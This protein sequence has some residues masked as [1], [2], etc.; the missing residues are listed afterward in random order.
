MPDLAVDSPWLVGGGIAMAV[1]LLIALTRRLAKTAITVIVV[2]LIVAG[3]Y[4]ARAEGY[5]TW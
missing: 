1:V 2:G 4:L 3:L 5:L